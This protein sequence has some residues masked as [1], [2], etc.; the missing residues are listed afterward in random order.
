MGIIQNINP[1]TMRPLEPGEILEVR[2][3]IG[4]MTA[5]YAVRVYGPAISA[6]Y[7]APKSDP[8]HLVLSGGIMAADFARFSDRRI[9]QQAKSIQL[10]LD[11][12]TWHH[13]E[14]GIVVM[15]DCGFQQQREQEQKEG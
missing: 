8:P 15:E 9:D 6:S 4:T 5:S 1:E 2:R 11:H 12:I 14:V 3:S 10:M 7:I 13:N